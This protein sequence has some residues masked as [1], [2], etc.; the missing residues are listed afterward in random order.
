MDLRIQYHATTETE[1]FLSGKYL[2]V[3]ARCHLDDL[4]IVFE[5]AESHQ[6]SMKISVNDRKSKEIL[7]KSLSMCSWQLSRNSGDKNS[8]NIEREFSEMETMKRNELFD[9]SRKKVT[10]LKINFFEMMKVE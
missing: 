1:K 8:R 9:S 2:T 3:Q 7:L 4:K 5:S 6:S 10:F